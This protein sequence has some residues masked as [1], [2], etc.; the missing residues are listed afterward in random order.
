MPFLSDHIKIPYLKFK[1]IVALIIGSSTFSYAQTDWVNYYVKKD[2]GIMSVTVDLN[3]YYSKPNY[4]NLLILGTKYR[5]CMNNGFPSEKGLEKLYTFSDSTNVVLDSITKNRLVGIITYQ[6]TGF[7]VYY[8]K[9][10]IDIRNK[11]NK[12]YNNKFNDSSNYIF[13]KRDK[14]WEYYFSNLFRK[15]ITE[16]FIIDHQYLGELVSK[17]DD[18][19]E[20]RKISHWIYFNSEKRR[21]KFIKAIKTFEF[22]IDSLNYK[23]EKNYKYELQISR[24]NNVDPNSISKL[25]QMLKN[26]STTGHGIYDGWKAE[27]IIKE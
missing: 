11:I 18:L 25:T 10:T 6:C 2:K 12:V 20:K 8:V 7:D 17:G 4:K 15:N 22:T 23:Q 1:I 24:K 9:D 16:D 3:L 13:I 21:A 26:L 5:D 14:K 27:A 19:S